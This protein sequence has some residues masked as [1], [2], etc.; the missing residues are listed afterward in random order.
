MALLL[1]TDGQTLALSGWL[2]DEENHEPV[3]NHHNA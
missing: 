1:R 2:R 3:L